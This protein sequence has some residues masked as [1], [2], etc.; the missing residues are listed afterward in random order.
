M[1][2]QLD[3]ELVAKL[4]EYI[5]TLDLEL[6]AH[7]AVLEALDQQGKLNSVLALASTKRVLADQINSKYDP[8]IQSLRSSSQ[9]E[10]SNSQALLDLLK[11]W[12][13]KGRKPV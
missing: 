6:E 8:A 9:D 10:K 2:F 11:R 1:T 7:K 5:K 12:P 4:L 13:T 3:G